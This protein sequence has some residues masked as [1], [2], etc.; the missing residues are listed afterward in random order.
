MDGHDEQTMRF[1]VHKNKSLLNG[2]MRT[3]QRER[4][5]AV[6]QLLTLSS[7]CPLTRGR[8]R[9]IFEIGVSLQ[10]LLPKMK[11]IA[12]TSS[13]MLECPEFAFFF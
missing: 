2:A 4:S 6:E 9:P 5:T 1:S 7:A 3:M 13:K 8:I 11:H 12:C 10:K